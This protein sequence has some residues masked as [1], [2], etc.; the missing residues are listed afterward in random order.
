[1]TR[2]R[3]I[4]WAIIAGQ[5]LMLALL[6]PLALWLGTVLP[7]DSPPTVLTYMLAGAAR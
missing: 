7:D 2:T 3:K 6:I 1:M 4:E 5:A